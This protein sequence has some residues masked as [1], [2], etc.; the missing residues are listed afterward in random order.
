MNISK[1]LG[2]M[3]LVTALS[4]SSQAFAVTNITDLGDIVNTSISPQSLLQVGSLTLPDLYTFDLSSNSNVIVSFKFIEGSISSGSTF[5]LF[6]PS[7]VPVTT[8]DVST[9]SVG[10][11]N[12]LNFTGLAAGNDY[13][14]KFTPTSSSTFS[15]QI[16]FTGTEVTP[17]PEAETNAMMLLGLGLIGMIARRKYA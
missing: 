4:F 8:Y 5:T 13:S 10:S 3:A 14:F 17:V 9:F 12:L 11:T 15:A 7:N 6:S 2:S 16:S 1:A